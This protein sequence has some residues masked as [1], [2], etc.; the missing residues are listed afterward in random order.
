[1]SIR[2]I[3]KVFSYQI[4]KKDIKINIE[5]S[6]IKSTGH[7]ENEVFSRIN[8]NLTEKKCTY[9]NPELDPVYDLV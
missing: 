8:R 2:V 7:I 4:C 6:H 1:M 9:L 5:S 3:N